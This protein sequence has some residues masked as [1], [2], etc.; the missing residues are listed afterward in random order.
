MDGYFIFFFFNEKLKKKIMVCI[1][2]IQGNFKSLERNVLV[3]IDEC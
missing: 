3:L 2:D 1:W